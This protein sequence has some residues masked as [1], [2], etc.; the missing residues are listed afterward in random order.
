[1][2]HIPAPQIDRAE[3]EEADAERSP[4]PASPPIPARQVSA[5]AFALGLL[6]ALG[7]CAVL[8]YNDYFVAA[9]Y[10]SGNFFPIAGVG[11]ILLLTLVINPLLLALGRP[12]ALWK[13]GEIITVWS[14]VLVVSGIPSS[15]LMRYLIP[16]LAAPHYFAS[17]QNGW[18]GLV[19]AGLPSRLLVTDPAAVHDFF[20]GLPRGASVPW[21][22][23]TVPLGWW[24]LF[25]ACLFTAFFCLS[26]LMRRQW[27]ENERLAFPLVQL[28]VLLSEAPEPGH[29]LNALM[30][31]PLLWS[32]VLL[33]TLIHTTK[34]LHLFY[35][36]SPDVLTPWH[37][38]QILTTP[39]W[40]GLN[41]IQLVV[42]PLVIGFAYLVPAEILFSL[43][44]FY[45]AHKLEILT[46]TLNAWDMSAAGGSGP[47]GFVTYQE[48]GGAIMVTVWVLWL[49]RRHLGEVWRKALWNDKSVDDAREP[50]PYRTAL[51]GLAGAYFGMYMWLTLAARMNGLMALGVLAG[52]FVIFLLISWLVAQGGLL[53]VQQTFAPS[54]LVTA[55]FG[56]SPFSPSS[57]AAASLTEHIGWNDSRELMLPSLLN[58]QKAADETRLSAR[59]LTHALAVCVM[60][61]VLVSAASSIWLPYTHGGGLALKNHWMY[62]D[63][64]QMPFRWAAGQARDPH[65][66]QLGAF[67]NM[68]GGALLVLTLF[69]CRTKLP[70]F[71]LHPSG[72]LIAGSYAMYMLWF[73]VFLGWLAKAPITHYGGAGA[74]RRLLP[75]FLGLILGDCLNALLW[76][77]IGLITG[78]GYTLLPI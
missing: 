77:G 50:L 20:E 19:L 46:G 24:G 43:W 11:A 52:S 31:A 44:F 69:V 23:W 67:L 36:T 3:A 10:L 48:A 26:A 72:F 64:P 29:R 49:A 60:L 27:V 68:L 73:S 16:H 25:V 59:S 42:Y 53:F 32:G 58:A 12:A 34:A 47:P 33:V 39:P 55:L 66:P 9:T 75:F 13:P 65:P 5:R 41:D 54:Q 74:Y 7:L 14:M 4:A 38:W 37:S 63:S 15:G 28:P 57:L 8:P 6:L 17:A 22:A 40:N 78:T 61:A 18:D 35:P 70:W 1:M 30:R 45:I 62:V 51:F 76:V 21:A 56:T 2:K 71:A